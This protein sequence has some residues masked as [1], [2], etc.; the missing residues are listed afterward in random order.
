MDKMYKIRDSLKEQIDR[1]ERSDLIFLLVMGLI[2]I[3]MTVVVFLYSV[4][5][6]NVVVD[7]P[8]MLPTLTTGDVLV[9]SKNKETERGSLIVIDG[10]K[11]ENSKGE[12][13]WLIKRAIALGGDTVQIK[14][15]NVYVNGEKISEPYLGLESSTT[16]NKDFHDWGKPTVIPEGEV[17]YLGDNRT[18]SSDS[19]IYGTCKEENIVGVVTDW[20]LSARGFNEFL[21]NTGKFFRGEK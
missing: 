2:I 16:F 1:K 18:N 3:A 8:S 21:Y 14:D 9:A 15:G 4:V 7:G 17:F 19:R 20:S 6:F 10:V 5:F 11:W 12:Y 13:V